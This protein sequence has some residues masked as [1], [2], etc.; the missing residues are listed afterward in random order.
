MTFF[1]KG[2][3]GESERF[4]GKNGALRWS[5]LVGK[6]KHNGQN[7]NSFSYCTGWLYESSGSY[8]Q[9]FFICGSVA[10]A[11]SL[12]LFIVSHMVRK[13]RRL[14]TFKSS[15]SKTADPSS[16]CVCEESI[17]TGSETC[18]LVGLSSQEVLVVTDKE[19]VL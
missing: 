1:R 5:I 3:R 12:L 15:P 19:T 9:A 17:E 7:L 8:H 18:A 6:Q 11:S 2:G 16:L 4:S 13:Q 10:I 14:F